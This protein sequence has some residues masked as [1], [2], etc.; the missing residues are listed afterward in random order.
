MA[1]LNNSD[2]I[3]L[4]ALLTET[5]ITQVAQKAGVSE[6][7]VYARLKNKTFKAAYEKAR[8]DLLESNKNA[9]QAQLSDAI[10]TLSEIMNN[11]DNA[12]QVRLN[13]SEAIMRN[14]LRLNEQLDILNRLNALEW[15]VMQ[16]E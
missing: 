16:N 13:A 15:Q 5:T 9:L 6:P 14:M 1:K 7:T 10:V 4:T 12:P 8:Q 2:N 3:I 11:K